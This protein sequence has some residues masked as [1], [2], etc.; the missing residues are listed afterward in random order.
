MAHHE[1]LTRQAVIEVEI[2]GQQLLLE[3]V[4]GFRQVGFNI[5]G[6]SGVRDRFQRNILGERVL[7]L[8]K[9]K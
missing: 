7:G 2:P 6:K 9:T 5:H 8:P 4:H 3:A 1:E